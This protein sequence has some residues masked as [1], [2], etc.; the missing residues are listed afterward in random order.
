[1][2][3]MVRFLMPAQLAL[4]ILAVTA[5]IGG[6]ATYAHA[7]GGCTNRSWRGAYVVAVNGF[8]TFQLPPQL[9]GA[10]GPVAV[11][12]TMTFD[13][14]GTVSRSL[15]VSYGGQDFPVIDSGTYSVNS[16]CTGLASFAA[17]GE[18]FSLVSVNKKTISLVTATPGASGAGTLVKQQIQ[19]CSQRQ[20]Q[21]TFVFTGNGLGAFQNPPLLIDAFFPVAVSGTWV[22]DGKGSVSRNLNLSFAGL[23]FPYQD[24]GSY[25]VKSDCTASAYFPNDSEPFAMVLVDAGTIVYSAQSVDGI[26]RAGTG[27]LARQHLDE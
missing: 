9:I 17:T 2:K 27:T 19:S 12:G 6:S 21:G 22:F 1:M 13:G 8:R 20:L 24:S 3:S 11:I 14:I 18:V 16:D 25:T 23:I 5:V 4:V 7:D 15:T 10:Y 26:S